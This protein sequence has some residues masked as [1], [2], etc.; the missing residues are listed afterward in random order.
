MNTTTSKIAPVSVPNAKM[1][2]NK[3]TNE[4]AT[5]MDALWYP[6][7]AR[8]RFVADT[9]DFPHAVR[10]SVVLGAFDISL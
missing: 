7:L 10:L 2:R 5:T 9:F 6:G 4:A 1:T 3:N 8:G